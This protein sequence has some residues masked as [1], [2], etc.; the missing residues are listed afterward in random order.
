MLVINTT[1]IFAISALVIGSSSLASARVG[2]VVIPRAN[3]HS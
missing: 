1:S 3:A 2:I